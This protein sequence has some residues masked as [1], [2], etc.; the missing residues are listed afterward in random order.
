LQFDNLNKINKFPIFAAN[1]FDS[2]NKLYYIGEVEY[3]EFIYKNF[4][5]FNKF[6]F[7]IGMPS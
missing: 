7:S 3:V 5:F 1:L 2:A 6:I 4:A